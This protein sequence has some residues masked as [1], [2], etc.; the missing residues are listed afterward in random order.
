M[1]PPYAADLIGR[2]SEKV[3]HYYLTRKITE[4][5]VLVNNATETGWFGVMT[6]AASAV[7]FPRS[8]VRFWQP[9]GA[10]GAPLQGQ[11]V[12]Y[13]G[14]D[15]EKFLHRFGTFGWGARIW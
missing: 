6:A 15:P 7:V 1:N 8:R 9:D 4:A 13:F 11:A 3:V 5:I 2:F 12:L 14:D 10:V